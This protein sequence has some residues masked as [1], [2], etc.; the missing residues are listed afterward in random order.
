MA[1]YYCLM[2]G[3]PE[4]AL[5]DAKPQVSVVEFR[6]QAS[7]ELSSLDARILEQYFF[8]EEDCRNLVRLLKNPDAEFLPGGNYSREQFE[9]LIKS[10]REINFNVHRYPAFMSEFARQWTYNK[11]VEGYFPEDEIIYQ[12]YN[13]VICNC[14]NVF[15]RHWYKLNLDI[16]NILT[17]VLA[18]QQGWSVGDFIKGDNEVTEMIRENKTRD[19]D[20]SHEFDYV[21]DLMKIVDEPDPVD[22]ERMIDSMKWL[23][24]DEYTFLD[25]FNFEA[26]F[27]YFCKLK[28]KER[29]AR[30]DVV[31]GKATFESIIDNLRGEARVP[32]EFK[33]NNDK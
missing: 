1:N 26:L 19:F 2:A 8:L 24:L 3:A 20:L 31:Q 12:F 16:N 29:W 22:K 14:R 27:A 10:A 18:R 30:L 4:L 32:A 25:P 11:D 28:I 7:M 6:E 9:D 5:T 17:A 15:V 21:K 13:Y 23:W 33:L